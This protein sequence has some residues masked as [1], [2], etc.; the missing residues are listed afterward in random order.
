MAKRRKRR[1]R[2]GAIKTQTCKVGASDARFMRLVKRGRFGLEVKFLHSA[3]VLARKNPQEPA[4]SQAKLAKS[5]KWQ[6]SKMKLKCFVRQGK[7]RECS[8]LSL[9]KPNYKAIA[10]CY[11]DRIGWGF[12][13]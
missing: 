12:K 3:R 9:F 8:E 4:K 10:S 5:M 2:Y 11:L 7:A 6:I 1:R 13:K